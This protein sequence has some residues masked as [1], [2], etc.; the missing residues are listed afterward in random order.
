MQSVVTHFLL[1][2]DSGAARRLRRSLA[3]QSAQT[4]VV[5]GV[6]SELVTMA[7]DS[8][9]LSLPQS[10]WNGEL[11]AGLASVPNTFWQDSYQNSPQETGSVVA[12]A[13]TQL[14]EETNPHDP[15]GTFNGLDLAGRGGAH[16]T[17]LAK[18]HDELGGALP[19]NL[20]VIELLLGTA[21]SEGIRRIRVYHVNDHPRLS[22]W[23]K[24]LVEHVNIDVGDVADESLES[25]LTGIFSGPVTASKSDSTLNA[26][27]EYLFDLPDNK[28]ELDDSLQWLGVRDFYEEAE[29]AVG[30]VQTM[31][32]D[33]STLNLSDIGLL[34]PEQVEYEGAIRDAFNIAGLPLAGLSD[35]SWRRD[36]GRELILNFLYVRQKPAPIMAV[37]A[38]LSSPLMPWSV[39]QGAT[40]AQNVIDGDW[41]V[42][43][44]HGISDDATRILEFLRRGDTKGG[45]LAYALRQFVSLLDASPDFETEV[46][47]ARIASEQ[48]C[49]VLE[50]KEPVEWPVLCRLVSPERLSNTADTEF[51]LEGLTIW[52]EGREAWHPVRH[53]LVLGFCAGHYPSRAHISPVF[54]EADVS[55]LMDMT[56][57]PLDTQRAKLNRARSL[58]KRQLNLVADSASFFVPRRDPAGDAQSPSEAMEFMSYLL[59]TDEDSDE[60]L[61][62]DLSADR[63]QARH[64]PQ[65]HEDDIEIPSVRP[66]GDIS[67]G[68]NLLAL[69]VDAEGNPK[70]ESPSALDKMMVSPLVWLLQRVYAEPAMW[71]AEDA[72]VLL[73]GTLSHDVFEHVFAQDSELPERSELPLMVKEVLAEVIGRSAPFMQASAWKVECR[74][75]EAEL[76]KAAQSWHD[77]LTELDADVIGT[78]IW[79]KGD[80]GTLA[81]HGQAD[82]LLSLPGNRLLIVDYKKSSSASRRGR[83]EKGY[84]SQV[85]LYR[86]MIQTGGLKDA[87]KAA[88]GDR[89]RESDG[90]GVVYFNM[91][92]SVA[93]SD[94]GLEESTK[95]PGWEVLDN[96]VSVEAMA[97]IQKRIADLKKGTIR[98]NRD[99]DAVFFE[100]KAGVKPYALGVTPL[101]EIFMLAEGEGEE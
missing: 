49:A 98:L 64:L 74:L 33:D 30:M 60:V 94:T 72:N 54:S 8:H 12:R 70:P 95:V 59:D 23:Q 2:P 36:L 24:G 58:F 6:W 19:D 84:D 66:Y 83:M 44:W 40:A 67:V 7:L 39:E 4:G 57:S 100:K 99:T 93:L 56:G 28:F 25:A 16:L 26:V 15:F 61:S 76:I 101:T 55:E 18:L 90:V 43:S 32:K 89:L 88:L 47:R 5:V 81:I 65:C 42:S 52:R 41:G 77:M 80:L 38:C 22:V 75:L 48:V 96:D 91:N 46:E 20:A 31:L 17:D 78:E 62:L 34:V 97:L 50:K 35:G 13:Y 3:T 92:D 27:Q 82:A 53:L 86:K 21:P 63:E 29:V 73:L 11:H 69:R 85:E 87:E 71:A 1:V 37:A 79:L 14:L 10:D 45:T 51:S 68:K 9:A